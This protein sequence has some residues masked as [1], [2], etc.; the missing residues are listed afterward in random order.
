M[1]R[2]RGVVGFGSRRGQ[3]I[4]FL[5]W[6]WVSSVCVLS[7]VVS[8]GDPDIVLTRNS[9]R[10]AIVYLSSALVHSLLL[11]YRHLTHRHLGYKSYIEGG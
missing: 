10:S 8:D 11:R 6:E 4:E 7:S 9:G 5:S 3:K 1:I 2:H